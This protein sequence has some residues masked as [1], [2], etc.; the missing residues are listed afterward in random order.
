MEG[1]ICLGPTNKKHR[2]RHRPNKH[3]RE[4]HKLSKDPV[5]I[6]TTCRIAEDDASTG[7]ERDCTNPRGYT[8]SAESQRE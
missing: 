1:G 4:K 3:I 7:N 8:N 2:K 6:L 5:S